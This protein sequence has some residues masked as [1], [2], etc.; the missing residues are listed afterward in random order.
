MFQSFRQRLVSGG[1]LPYYSTPANLV[2]RLVYYNLARRWMEPVSLRRLVP[3]LD[4]V[5]ELPTGVDVQQR[6][7]QWPWEEGLPGEMQHDRRILAD[8]VQ[9]DRLG[10]SRRDLAHDED[11]LSFEALEMR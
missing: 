11:G 10:E 3:E 4:H 9:H 8:R 1:R 5:P 2:A 7:W 6:E